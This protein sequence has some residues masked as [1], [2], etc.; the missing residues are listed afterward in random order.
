VAFSECGVVNIAEFGAGG[1]WP[2]REVRLVAAIGSLAA[3]V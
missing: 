2:G 3:A 1:G